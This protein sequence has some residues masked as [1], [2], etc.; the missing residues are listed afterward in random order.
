MAPPLQHLPVLQPVGAERPAAV[1]S[2]ALRSSRHGQLV[3][4]DGVCDLL[5]FTK[6]N[7]NLILT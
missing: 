1:S 5:S 3:R 7:L 2:L 6:A 4:Q